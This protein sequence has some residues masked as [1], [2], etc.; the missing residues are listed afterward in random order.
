MRF[1]KRPNTL[2]LKTSFTLSFG[3][4]CFSLLSALLIF[5]FILSPMAHRAADDLG[6]LMHII[7]KS[8]V[9]LP[10]QKKQAF[11][12]HLRQQHFLFITDKNEPVIPIEKT[13]PFISRLEQALHHH[14]GQL[15]T[16]MQ[17]KDDENCFWVAIPL[18]KQIVKIGFLH[19]RIG[20][21][22]LKAITGIVAT[23]C[24]LIMIATILMVRRITRPITTLS[25]AVKLLGAGNLSTRIQETGSEELVLM[26]R[27]FNRMAE[28]ITLL[29]TN[30]NLLFGGISHDLRTPI[31]RI[32]IALELIEGVENTA[33]IS[34][35][36]NDLDEMDAIIKHT[37]E[38][39]KGMD[40]YHAVTIEI[41][42]VIDSIVADYQRHGHII[43]WKKSECGIC[44]I[45][46]N[47]LRRVLC[48]LLDNAFRYGEGRLVTLLCS[49]NK[50]TLVV[51]IID[52]GPGIPVDKLDAVFQPFYRLDNSRNKK[53]GGSGLGLTI[54]RQLCDIHHWE[55]QLIPGKKTGLEVRLEIPLA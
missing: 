19:A 24:L 54:V 26:A 14:T 52:Q 46:V 2:Y 4:V 29:L 13:F 40:R 3:L 6:G 41:N 50:G 1:F 34:G 20:P 12:S 53:T 32:K 37:L 35:I 28:E 27:N 18:G 21:R 38:L 55:I 30:R 15:I 36:S 23:A 48:N 31:T 22:P 17:S 42:E 11:Q 9:A 44:K 8:W 33:Y 16:V 43:E 7:S 10:E 39:I 45:E 51:N 25:D 47:A 5:I 49:K